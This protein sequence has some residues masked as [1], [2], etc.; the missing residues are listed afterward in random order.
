MHQSNLFGSSCQ[1]QRLALQDAKIL[2]WPEFVANEIADPWFA[3][4][5]Q[6]IN[7]Q[8]DTI[9][10]FAK[11]HLTPRLSYWVGQE[12]MTYCY[13]QHTMMPNKWT[14]LLR[15]IKQ[16][17]EQVC[18]STFNSVLL[19]YYRD[20]KDSNG[21]HSDD[22]PEL[23]H[24]P[25]IASLSLGAARDFHLR[26]KENRQVHKMNLKPGSLLLMSGKTQAC[27]QHHIPKRAS[28]EPRINLTFR[29]V[30]ARKKRAL[31]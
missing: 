9:T 8:Q 19:N 18:G 14:P 3:E 24:E 28:A 1:V 15:L 20:G 23:G 25:V 4:L 11:Q 6:K 27:W 12:W 16:R 13:S 22:E 2:H 30:F 26:H 5:E 17:V 29:T 31:I 21:W 10:V 7:W